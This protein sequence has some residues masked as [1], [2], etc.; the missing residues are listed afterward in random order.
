MSVVEYFG[1]QASVMGVAMALAPLLQ[2]RRIVA[3]RHAG[4]VSQAF[5][6]IIVVGAGAWAAYGLVKPD[7]YVAVPNLLGVVTNLATVLL[8]RS[9][10][11]RP[12]SI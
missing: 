2:V 1:I 6:W 4:D 12:E 7:W 9:Y 8:A 10:G 3:R 5:I 11:A